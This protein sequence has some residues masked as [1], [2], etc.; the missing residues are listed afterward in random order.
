[1]THKPKIFLLVSAAI[2]LA[3]AVFAVRREL[4]TDTEVSGLTQQPPAPVVPIAETAFEQAEFSFYGDTFKLKGGRADVLGHAWSATSTP[5][6][7]IE[8]TLAAT[9]TGELDARGPGGA[10]AAVTRGFGADLR[11]TT[12]FVFRAEDGA[13]KQVAA[14]VAYQ[15][16]AKVV[17]VALDN[18]VV[19][20]RLLT[21][22]DADAELPHD[23][24]NLTKPLTLLFEISGGRLTP[25]IPHD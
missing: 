11:W 5:L 10:V 6:I 7:P 14:G 18:G 19:T 1:M 4:V 25:F 20:L 2:I 22:S 3:L 24:R 9:A 15:A 23:R 16:D 13:L 12:L 17:S 8:Y 21:V